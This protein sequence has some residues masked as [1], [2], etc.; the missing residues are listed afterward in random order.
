MRRFILRRII[1]SLLLFWF[2]MTLSFILVNLT[3]GGPER[4]LMANPRVT[5]EDL[6]NM[7]KAFGLNDP[8]Y[9]QY[10][11]WLFNSVTF[12]FGT[13]YKHNLPVLQVIGERIWPTLQLGIAAYLISLIGIPLG[14][15]AARHR[16]KLGDNL[17]RFGTVVGSAMPAWWMA[18]MLIIILS[19]TIGWFPQGQ[20]TGGPGPWLLH[21]LIPAALLSTSELIR[22]SRFVRSETLEVLS[23]DYVRTARAKGITPGEVTRRHVLRNSLIPVV[24]LFGSFLPTV[25]SGAIIT[26]TIF[27]WPGMGRLFFE[28]AYA[29][30]YPV[31]LTILLIGTFFTIIGTFVADLAYGFVDPRIHYR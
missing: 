28:S 1:Q 9:V 14:I 30:D 19:N 3:P 21:L 26:E 13:S 27:N 18:L 20:G 6:D 10:G 17:V 15:Y 16:G 8:L 7:R 5:Q 29:R 25:L 11:R 2:V 4:S 23:Q 24:T 12:N 22:F 31:I